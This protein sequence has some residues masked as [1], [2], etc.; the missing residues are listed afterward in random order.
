MNSI[1]IGN[2]EIG[3]SLCEVLKP[4]YL[5]TVK[6]REHIFGAMTIGCFEI[7]HI[8][9]PWSDKFIEIVKQYQLEFK[10]KYTIIHS[11]VPVGTSRKL[12]AIHSPVLGIH[13]NLALSIKTFQ[14]MIGGEQA[15]EVADY[16]RRCGMKVYLF[17]KQETTEL[18]KI[19]DTTFYGVCLE[20]T[21]DVKRE[22]DKAE[23]PFEAW[24]I[25]TANYNKGYKELDCPEFTRPNL[26]PIMK[27][28][29]GHC[30]LQN[31]ELHETLFTK[32]IK[33][34]NEEVTK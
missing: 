24:S 33:K 28:L 16:F 7:M 34:L 31:C 27:K 9:I 15:S 19:L 17:D 29:G 14:K 11:T 18:M 12:N 10:P 8:C 26:V 23:V 22:C 1:I 6:D 5:V 21:K 32:L 2:G 3:K 4:H 25:W 13:P 20:Y 30:V